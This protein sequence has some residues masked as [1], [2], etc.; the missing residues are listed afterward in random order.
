[1]LHLPQRH[2]G[3]DLGIQ[4]QEAYRMPQLCQGLLPTQIGNSKSS[5]CHITKF[6]NY[7]FSCPFC[8]DKA[9]FTTL[10]IPKLIRVAIRKIER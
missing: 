6:A 10:K 2:E 3:K 8:L 9:L 7:H 1:M 4:M 5:I